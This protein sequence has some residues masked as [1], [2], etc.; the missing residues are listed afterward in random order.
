MKFLFSIFLVILCFACMQ[1]LDSCESGHGRVYKNGN[2]FECPFTFR[3]RNAQ[4][5]WENVEKPRIIP[6]DADDYFPTSLRNSWSMYNVFMLVP[7]KSFTEEQYT[8]SL[9]AFD[10]GFKPYGKPK[11]LFFYRAAEENDMVE[12]RTYKDGEGQFVFFAQREMPPYDW[13]QVI[14]VGDYG[15]NFKFKGEVIK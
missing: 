10:A 12:Y 9:Q 14:N 2:E 6:K 5:E 3:V 8:V 15:N 7:K 13:Y 4:M 1:E 11:E